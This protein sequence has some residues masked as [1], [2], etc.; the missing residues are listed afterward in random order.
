MRERNSPIEEP[1]A[2]LERL[3]IDEFLRARGHTAQTV[4]Q[5]P[6]AE[7]AARISAAA[8]H[9]SLRLAE[10]EARAHYVDELHRPE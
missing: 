7:A 8:E 1:H 9:A 10:I 6:A 4:S 5:L 3:L 2:S